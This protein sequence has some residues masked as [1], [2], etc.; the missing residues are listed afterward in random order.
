MSQTFNIKQGDTEPSLE[1]I[2]RD[3]QRQPR[4]LSN[5]DSVRFHMKNVSTQDTVVDASAA[6]INESEGRVVYDWSSGD[7]DQE[8]RHEAEFEVTYNG[9][10]VETFPNSGSIEVYVDEEIA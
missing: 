9:G 7:T 4:D 5:A 3:S 2:L 8:G 10:D 6:V 1:A